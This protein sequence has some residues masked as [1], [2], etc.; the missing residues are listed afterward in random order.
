MDRG[1]WCHIEGVVTKNLS[2]W[3]DKVRPSLLT[4]T[5]H[6]T[7]IDPGSSKDYKRKLIV[8]PNLLGPNLSKL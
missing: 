7:S 2:T 6:A 5:S 8:D 3:V 1:W 4:R